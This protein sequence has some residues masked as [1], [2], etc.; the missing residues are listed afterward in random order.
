[1]FRSLRLSGDATIGNKNGRWDLGEDGL[2]TVIGTGGSNYNLTCLQGNYSEWHAVTIDPNLGNIDYILTSGNTWFLEGM[3]SS[4]G[5]PTNVLTLHSGVTMDIRHGPNNDDNGYAKIIH[6]QTGAQFIYRPGGGAGDYY[7]KTSLQIDNGASMNFYNANGGNNTGTHVGGTTALNGLV[8]ISIGDSPV[9]FTNVISGSGGFFWDSYNNALTFSADNTYTGPSIIANGLTLALTG[10]GA[11]SHSASIFFGG[12]D[13]TSLR[14]DAS[15]RTD[16]TF[17]LASGQTLAGIGGI[18][19]N[20]TISPG[21]T[22][23]PAGTNST[24]G[25]T[26]LIGMI[27]ATGN[28][29]LNG[30]TIIKLNGAGVSDSVQA[31]GNIQ[32]AGTLNLANVSGSPLAAGNTFHIFSGTGYSG[33]FSGIVPATPGAGLAW[34][35]TQLSSGSLNVIASGTVSQPVLGGATVSGT[36]FVFSGTNGAAGGNY[37]V[38]TSTNLTT[39]VANWTPLVTNTFDVNGAFHFT[40][41]INPGAGPGFYLLKV[42]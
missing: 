22:L 10:N 39:P 6:V 12:T 3:G 15:G 34:D 8:H 42:Q 18:K 16:G 36:N 13:G 38:F 40:N 7:L 35:T 24:I 9:T 27:S 20:L 21:A 31:G 30:T 2:L 14:L 41:G 25:N 17:T 26:N 32:Y 29:S 1:L 5:N 28:I 33:S 19:G 23:S 4:L 11:I 37:V